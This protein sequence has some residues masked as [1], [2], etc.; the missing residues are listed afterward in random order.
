MTLKTI[1]ERLGGDLYDGGRR[2]SIPAPGHS[3][4]DRSVSLLLAEGRILIHCFGAAD[5]RVVR[6]QLLGLGLLDAPPTDAW[7]NPAAPRPGT[8]SERQRLEAA[9]R[10]WDQGRPLARTLSARHCRLRGIDGPLPSADAMRHGPETPL[11][12]Y[13]EDAASQ[14]ALLAAL[15]DPAGELAAVEI[16]YL[17]PNGH[18]AARMR[19]SR[20]LVGV[21][22]PG[23][24]V[25]L[26][27][28]AAHMLVAEGVFTTLSAC[29]RFDLPGWALTSAGNLRRWRAP[30]GVRRVTIAADRGPAGEAAAENLRQALSADGVDAVVHLP[31]PPFGDWNEAAAGKEKG[32]VGTGASYDRQDVPRRR[33]WRSPMTAAQL[34]ANA[35]GHIRIRLSDLGL[36]PENLRFDEPADDGIAQ[37]ADTILAA[38]V[39]IPPIVRRGRKGEQDYMALDGR[40]RRLALLLLRDRG[41]IDETYEVDC[42]LARDQAARAAAVVLPNAERAPV[43]VADVILAIGKLRKG[44]MDTAKIA[45]ALG[46]ADLEIRRLEA[47]SQ[48]HAKVL[49]GLRLGRLTLKQVRMFARLPDKVRQGELAQTALD[50]YF[51]EHLLRQVVECDQVTL[52][53]ARL[54]LVGLDAYAQAGGRVLSDLFGE[55]PDRLLDADLLDRLWRSRV[56]LLCERLKA[57]GLVAFI[58]EGSTYRP[59][60]G[61]DL[62]RYGRLLSAEDAAAL[63]AAREAYAALTESF[64]DVDLTQEP[65]IDRLADL[66]VA[67]KA[68]KQVGLKAPVGAVLLSPGHEFG[69]D[70]TFFSQVQPDAPEDAD[71][72]DEDVEAELA[73][74][75]RS[76][77]P[78]VEVPGVEV[79]VEGSSHVLHETRTHVATC[80]LIRD[81]ADHPDAALTALLAQ[82]FK[83]LALRG[84]GRG[85]ESALAISA[86]AYRRSGSTAIDQLDGEVLARLAGRREAYLASGMRPI[87]WIDQLVHG[88]K[89][90]LLAELTAISLN[91]R[92]PRTTSI[93]TS[94]RAEAAEIAELCGADISVHWTPD[95]AYLATHSKRQLLALHLEMGLDDPRAAG[96]KKDELVA[97]TLEA[98]AERRWAPQILSWIAVEASDPEHAPDQAVDASLASAAADRTAPADAGDGGE[99]QELQQAA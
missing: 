51:H 25:R 44:G 58:A 81:L 24:A 92:E 33:R 35:S 48:V 74:G 46:Y 99:T 77:P 55:M 2:A 76:D 10:I 71:D 83:N 12:V 82:L 47:L 50:G 49:D 57:E 75:G 98:C 59:P 5:W 95:A 36:A 11:A 97:F 52:N 40:R 56:E 65:A 61:Y 32:R 60:D 31:P 30:L 18:R 16:T 88:E 13:R 73:H 23:S 34:T 8:G 84:Y 28:A 80:G 85:E 93:R 53:D 39:I 96:L 38:G 45:S 27:P 63:E 42:I 69:L 7:A 87:A 43:H 19:L 20:K 67:L 79:D 3:A 37:L 90:A 72:L 26:A 89:M 70:M 41:D 91:L 66:V 86:S 29:R 1:V 4:A 94:A 9:R 22:P 64:G 14:P 21:V 6:D 17:A 62:L 78:D 15:R 68:I 54:L